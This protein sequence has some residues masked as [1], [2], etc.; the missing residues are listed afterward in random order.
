MQKSQNPTSM[1]LFLLQALMRS[2]A[3]RFGVSFE[4][5]W[6][7][8]YSAKQ[9]TI[10][11]GFRGQSFGFRVPFRVKGTSRSLR[12]RRAPPHARLVNPSRQVPNAGLRHSH[13]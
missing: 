13:H 4:L 2:V 3:L 5:K 7:E 12:H 1:H 6:T 8:S 9:E 11:K 10:P